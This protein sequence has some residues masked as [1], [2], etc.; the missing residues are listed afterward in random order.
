MGSRDT[1]ARCELNGMDACK[2]LTRRNLANGMNGITHRT[3]P[4]EW[5][6][7]ALRDNEML[8]SPTLDVTHSWS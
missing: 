6:S 8:I 1:F 4:S 5:P 3:A 7:T 2:L